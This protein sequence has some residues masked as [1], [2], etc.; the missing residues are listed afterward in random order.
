MKKNV[1]TMVTTKK[2]LKRIKNIYDI[3][4]NLHFVA[5]CQK[6]KNTEHG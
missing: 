5:F 1:T 2:G 3:V 6:Q 4:K